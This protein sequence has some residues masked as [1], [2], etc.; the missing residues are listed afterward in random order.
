MMSQRTNPGIE[1]VLRPLLETRV[2]NPQ[3]VSDQEKMARVISPNLAKLV[4]STLLVELRQESII[5]GLIALLFAG[6]AIAMIAL[7]LQAAG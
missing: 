2:G 4:Q 1:Q 6:A 7:F 3:S 5:N